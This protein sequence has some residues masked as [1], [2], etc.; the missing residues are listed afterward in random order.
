[1]QVVPVGWR[2]VPGHNGYPCQGGGEAQHQHFSQK[3]LIANRH[4]A[5]GSIWGMLKVGFIAIL[6]HPK[7]TPD[8]RI[9][10]LR[11]MKH[12]GAI[13]LWIGLG[14]KSLDGVR[15]HCR[16]SICFHFC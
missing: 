6:I 1:M 11:R 10:R 3:I 2:D 7:D 15:Q 5:T 4:K 9:T 12:R 8:D 14:W 13:S 16:L